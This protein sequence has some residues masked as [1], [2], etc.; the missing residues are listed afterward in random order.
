[1]LAGKAFHVLGCGQVTNDRNRG[2]KKY[3]NKMHSENMEYQKDEYIHVFSKQE[4]K[5]TKQK[6]VWKSPLNLF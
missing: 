3:Q 6:E 4:K 5:K 2:E 1:M